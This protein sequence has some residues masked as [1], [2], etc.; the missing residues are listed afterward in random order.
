[1]Q[2]KIEKHLLSDHSEV[3]DVIIDG[4]ARL[5]ACDLRDAEEL[6]EIICAAVERLTVST[7]ERV[8]DTAA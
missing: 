4:K 2:I 1:M 7:V 3:F 8:F 6:V 5:H